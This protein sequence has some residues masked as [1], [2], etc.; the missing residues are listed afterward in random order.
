ML[1]VLIFVLLAAAAAAQQSLTVTFSALDKRGEPVTTLRADDVRVEHDGK[2]IPVQELRFDPRQ[3]LD[4]VVL[5]D[6]SYSQRSAL[7]EIRDAAGEVLRQLQLRRTDLLSLIVF[8][9][10]VHEERAGIDLDE[11]D[12]MLYSSWPIGT[13]AIYDSIERAREHFSPEP[14]YRRVVLLLSDGEDSASRRLSPAD[15]PRSLAEAGAVLFA[16]DLNPMVLGGQPKA[17]QVLDRMAHAS[18][19]E[20]CYPRTE[21]Q[22][23]KC[24]AMIAAAARA[25][26][27]ATLGAIEAV[28]ELHKLKLHGPKGVRILAPA[29]HAD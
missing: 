28:P 21:G 6:V 8:S 23:K 25:T 14:G 2:L 3:R 1:R 15:V 9:D 11:A 13:S 7:D 17:G 12:K 10:K 26:Y 4:V 22:M 27:V 5:F 20:S 24:A 19:G 29:R 18:G 16:V